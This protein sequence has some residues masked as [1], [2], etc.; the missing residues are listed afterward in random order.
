MM[1]SLLVLVICMGLRIAQSTRARKTGAL[2]P[3]WLDMLRV[4]PCLIVFSIP[5]WAAETLTFEK[6]V[7]PIL[8]T[9]CFQCH[10]EDG[11]TKSGLDVRLARFI[12][13]GGEDGPAII[14]GKAAESLLRPYSICLTT[15]Q[16]IDLTLFLTTF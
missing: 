12:M 6:N 14:P 7:R 8:K 10:G 16:R 9:H 2:A 4:L 11:E 15:G 3:V 1:R 13:K 5:S